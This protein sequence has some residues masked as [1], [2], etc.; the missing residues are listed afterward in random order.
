VSE[1][2]QHVLG[3]G[4]FNAGTPPPILHG[5]LKNC[6]VH[7][8]LVFIDGSLYKY[9]FLT[10]LTCF[11]RSLSTIT[12]L[13]TNSSPN[14]LSILPDYILMFCTNL[15]IILSVHIYFYN[16]SV[17]KLLCFKHLP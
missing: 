4:Q 1:P 17:L 14:S 16:L 7:V 6:I 3:G 8:S 13:T 9:V 15:L 5:L 12:F 2:H 11:Y 10:V